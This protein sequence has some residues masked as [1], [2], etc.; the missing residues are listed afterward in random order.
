M[1][2]RS[3]ATTDDTRRRLD[4]NPGSRTSEQFWEERYG[5]LAEPPDG[6]PTAALVRFAFG[7]DP[8]TALDL[9]CARGDD[10]IWLA[11]QGWRVTGVD[12]SRTA[13]SAA[14]H[15]AEER[16]IADRTRFERH[17]FGASFPDGHFDL[18]SAM[19]LHSPIE[20]GRVATLRRAAK[21]VAAKGLLL[22]VT[23]GSRPPWS[24]AAKD[25]VFP[26]AREELDALSL[27]PRVWREVFVGE[28]T[29]E[30]TGPSN[31][32]ADVIDLIVALERK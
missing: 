30:A 8:G 2:E 22:L 24:W 1:K 32:R 9:G 6:Q 23:H 12:I 20:F 29:R 16:G 28:L 11:Q 14:Q 13:L 18:V 15:A 5:A 10:T 19:F 26:T 17:D 3:I 25:K 31:Q 4:P 21:A 27:D 7:R